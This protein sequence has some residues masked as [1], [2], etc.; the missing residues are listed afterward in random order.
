[1]SKEYI[2]TL[3]VLNLK[4]AQKV[5]KLEKIVEK[6]QKIINQYTKITGNIK[7]VFV[8]KIIK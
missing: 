1:M 3:E 2:K 4:L 8:N 7:G 5:K 6:Q